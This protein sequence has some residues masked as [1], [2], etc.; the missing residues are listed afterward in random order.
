MATASSFMFGWCSFRPSALT[1]GIV[2]LASGNV[3]GEGERMVKT[4]KMPFTPRPVDPRAEG[5]LA[6]IVSI[7]EAMKEA[8]KVRKGEAAK[9]ARLISQ[10][11]KFGV[12]LDRIAKEMGV[13]RERVRQLEA[14]K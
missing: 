12:S 4:V 1:L 11:R 13:T 14:G 7:T 9:R 3:K 6:E 5:V 2:V 10:A 8:E